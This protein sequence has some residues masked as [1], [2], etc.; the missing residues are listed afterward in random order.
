MV[1]YNTYDYYI[2]Y[3]YSVLSLLNAQSINFFFVKLIVKNYEQVL[4][5]S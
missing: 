4:R 5:F 3:D 1:S 2:T